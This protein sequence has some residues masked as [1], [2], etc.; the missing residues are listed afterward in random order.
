MGKRIILAG[1]T[2]L[3]GSAAAPLLADAG[4]DVHV[5]SRR[6]MPA[7]KGVTCHVA[8]TDQWPKL[9]HEIEADIAVSCLGTTMRIAGSQVAFAAVDLDLVCD[10]A[11]A[12]KASGASHFISVSS[13]G[14]STANNNFYLKTKGKMEAAIE[15]IGFERTDF[16]RPGLLRGERGGVTRYGEQFGKLLSPFTDMLMI[17]PLQRYRSIAANDVA[18]AICALARQ[19]NLGS[20][21]YENDA[22][23]M[24]AKG[25][26]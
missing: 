23:L 5:L 6:E 4:F 10:F 7:V 17:G 20:N 9:A 11:S 19:L 8:P 25:P 2:G 21:I 14:A 15:A 12:A 16:L 26:A 22:I 3:I 18:S 13:V 1:A 24:L